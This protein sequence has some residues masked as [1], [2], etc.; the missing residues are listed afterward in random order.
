VVVVMML[1][2]QTLHVLMQSTQGNATS[3][4]ASGSSLL[5]QLAMVRV[6]R[7]IRIVRVVRVIRVLRFFRELRMMLHSI[8]RS[9]KS[10]T[11]AML[12]LAMTFYIFGISLTQGTIDYCNS[13]AAWSDSETDDLR[14]RFGTLD[15][16]VLS[17]FQ[18]MSNGISWGEL[19]TALDPL[20]AAYRFMFLLF[21]SFAT[22]AVVNIV[23][24]IFVD[25]A[26]QT[27]QEDRE[28]VIQ[29]EVYSKENYMDSM[30]KVFEEMDTDGSGAINLTE[31]Q[32]AIEDERMVAYFNALGLDIT[33]AQTLFVLLDRDQTGSIDIEEFLLGCLRLKGEA[34]SLDMAKLMY[35]SEYVVHNVETLTQVVGDLLKRIPQGQPVSP[36]PTDSL[37]SHNFHETTG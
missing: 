36:L 31:F 18:A 35:E 29:E 24:G 23:T 17:L 16:S 25:S 3:T 19:L 32:D 6:L 21:V 26:M 14:T 9:F 27:S 30:Q 20:H 4:S 37:H 15:R 12:V 34:R 10:L 7:I 28:I 33:D 1:I 13:R 2:E 22:F 8:L 11:W 5:S